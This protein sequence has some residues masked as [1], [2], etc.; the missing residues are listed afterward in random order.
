[1]T[2][3]EMEKVREAFKLVDQACVVLVSVKYKDLWKESNKLRELLISEIT[4][5]RD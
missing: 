5:E 2:I 1:M 4:K 3:E